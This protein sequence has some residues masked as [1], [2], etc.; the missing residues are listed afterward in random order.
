MKKYQ[1]IIVGAG[2]AG[3]ACATVLARSGVEVLVLERRNRVGPKIC[4]GGITWSGLQQ[5]VPEALLQRVFP[6]QH[7]RTP[8]QR[9]K[10]SASLP[11]VST[12]NRGELG[13]WQLAQARAAGATV[14][15][16]VAVTRLAADRI[17]AG[18][19]TFGF[20]YL[21]GADGSG[22]KVRQ[23]LGLPAQAVGAGVN[24][25]V[26][27]DFERMEWHLEPRLF[28]NGYAWIFPHRGC[29]SIGAYASRL[30]TRPRI[31][32]KNFL[33]WANKHGINLGSV[34]MTAA[35]I[36]YDFRGWRFGNFFLVGDAA[37]LASPLTGEGIFPA[38]VSGEEAARAILDPAYRAPELA[39]LLVRHRSHLR[40]LKLTGATPWTCRLALE[41]LVLALRTG[42]V[43]F[44]ALEMAGQ[45]V[46]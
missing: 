7:V 10:I 22:S 16:P 39:G 42:L 13:Q 17:E 2:P 18:G 1:A 44:T 43:P 11:L 30:T 19:E 8:W 23:Y 27:G 12:V 25:F 5:R 38:I 9:T 21:V 45:P 14:L 46:R 40:L 31:L 35:L 24:C 15:N 3:L 33:R 26:P 32:Q 6:D 41:G 29:A 4:A 34:K 20:R 37:G 36:N 28:N